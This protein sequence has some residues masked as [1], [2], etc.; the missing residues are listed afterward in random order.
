MPGLPR[1]TFLLL[2]TIA[3]AAGCPDGGGPSGDDDGGADDGRR[4]DGGGEVTDAGCT[5]PRLVCGGR[6]VD[7]LTNSDNCG[8]CYIACEP[9]HGVGECVV[10]E[11]IVEC[12]PGWVDANGAA[13]DGCEYACTPTAE[14][15]DR[16][17]TCLDFVDN[18]CDGR[19]DGTDPDCADCVPEFCNA[20]DDD[21]DGLTDEDFD[22]DFDPLN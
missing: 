1:R 9:A 10:G 12:E 8:D 19:T 7:P 18:D 4:D 22:R 15:E 17:T 3:L 20:L 21:C 14:V 6:C 5:S 11:C 16:A 2:T 13:V